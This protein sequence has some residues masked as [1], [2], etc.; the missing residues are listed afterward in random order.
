MGAML[1]NHHDPYIQ[2]GYRP[3]VILVYSGTRVGHTYV[4]SC[5][6]A[7]VKLLVSSTLRT[8][9]GIYIMYTYKHMCDQNDNVSITLVELYLHV[10][11]LVFNWVMIKVYCLSIKYIVH[12]VINGNV[13]VLW[14][15]ECMKYFCTPHGH[16]SMC[17]VRVSEISDL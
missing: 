5:I 8:H 11:S 4:C 17:I 6:C 9:K 10:R 13:W 3:F 7:C 14:C 2:R 1:A 12:A 16:D 15:V